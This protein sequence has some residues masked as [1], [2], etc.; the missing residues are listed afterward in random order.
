MN[1]ENLL[2]LLTDSTI[3]KLYPSQRRD[4]FFNAKRLLSKYFVPYSGQ[5]T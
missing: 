5:S 1:I 4:Y 3:E 2:E